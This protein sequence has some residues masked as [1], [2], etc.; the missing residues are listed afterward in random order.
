[1]DMLAELP[2]Y[3]KTLAAR[4][5]EAHNVCEEHRNIATASL[6]EFWVDE[7]RAAHVVPIRGEPPRRRRRPLMPG[8]LERSS[9]RLH[10]LKHDHG[11][12]IA[13]V[14]KLRDPNVP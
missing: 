7:N 2:E 6:M 5:R 10:A 13:F 3:N 9:L 14:F 4:L 12:L 8:R 1:L 11:L